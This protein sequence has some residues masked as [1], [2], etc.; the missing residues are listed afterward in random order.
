MDA[1]CDP[2]VRQV[3]AM[4]SAQVGK[5]EI[6]LNVVGYFVDQDP[7]P[8]LMLQPTVEMAESFSKDRLAP[9]LRDTP[10]L[11]GKVAD[12]RAR[13]SGNTT[14]HKRFPGG[15]VTLA[16]ANSPASLASRPIRVVLCDEVDR[17]RCRWPSS[18]AQPGGIGLS[19]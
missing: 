8:I 11:R 19:C 14:L 10:A 13:D 12:P 1:V 16:G 18:A 3:V 17:T 4:T 5:S 15:H 9:M 2:S 6:L 7:S